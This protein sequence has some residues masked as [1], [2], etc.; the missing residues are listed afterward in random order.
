M[1]T[2]NARQKS[3]SLI[4]KGTMM[5]MVLCALALASGCNRI[6]RLEYARPAATHPTGLKVALDVRNDRPR[7]LPI[8]NGTTRITARISRILMTSKADRVVASPEATGSG[9]VG[10]AGV[11]GSEGSDPTGADSGV[12]LA[13]A[14]ASPCGALG[15]DWPVGCVCV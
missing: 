7:A 4:L 13:G 5:A 3:S 2:H 9:A 8:R 15:V 14:A 11:A 12:A 1:S 6:I 10:A